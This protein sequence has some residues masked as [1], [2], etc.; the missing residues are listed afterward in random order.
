ME[1]IQALQ[2]FSRQSHKNRLVFIDTTVEDYQSLVHGVLPNTEVVILDADRDGV[3]QVSKILAGR[4]GIAS[5]HIVSHGAPGRVYLGN[6]ELSKHLLKNY[7]NQLMNWSQALSSDA[8]ILLYGCDVAQTELGKAFVQG[9]SELT[10]ATVLAS[11]NRTGSAKL[12]GDWEL[13]VTTKS[14]NVSLA[15]ESWKL[16]LKV[17]M[18]PLPLSRQL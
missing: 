14:S 9:L 17:V 8:Q 3:E 4:I 13:E 6:T 7:A 15:F 10:G 1:N 2:L 12:G 18:F 11:D 5:L 16:Q